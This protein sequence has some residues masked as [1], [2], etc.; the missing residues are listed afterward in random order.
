MPSF[1]F[2]TFYAIV[3][4]CGLMPVFCVLYLES[5][6]GLEDSKNPCSKSSMFVLR[7]NLITALDSHA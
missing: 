3:Q 5:E 2:R 6:G 1:V 4:F 7:V